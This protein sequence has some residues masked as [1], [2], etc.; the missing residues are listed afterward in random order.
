MFFKRKDKKRNADVINLSDI[1]KSYAKYAEN[2]KIEHIDLAALAAEMIASTTIPDLKRIYVICR[3][4]IKLSDAQQIV[5]EAAATNLA[6]ISKTVPL[7]WCAAYPDALC[8]DI[9]LL[10]L[11]LGYI[12]ANEGNTYLKSDSMVIK[13]EGKY[14]GYDYL[15]IGLVEK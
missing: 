13:V 10:Q 14:N 12:N 15:V 3:D 4:N 6:L 1:D 8:G 9:S 11:L 2:V 5:L 7:V